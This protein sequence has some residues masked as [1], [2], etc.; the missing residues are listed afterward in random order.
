LVRG[1][2]LTT[3]P[4]S[5]AHSIFEGTA[6]DFCYGR[7]FNPDADIPD[8]WRDPFGAGKGSLDAFM[9]TW[10]LDKHQD[11]WWGLAIQRGEW[12]CHG[13]LMILGQRPPYRLIIR[14]GDP[15]QGIGYEFRKAG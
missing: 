8:A 5:I 9:G 4:A 6:N 11:I 1:S 12:G 10:R 13:C 15:D 2:Q 7:R 3:H 14:V